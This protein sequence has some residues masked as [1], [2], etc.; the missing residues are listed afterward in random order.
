M[1]LV[2]AFATVA[3]ALPVRDTLVVSSAPGAPLRSIAAA[4]RVARPGDVIRV[5]PGVYREPMIVVDRPVEILG[6]G[7]PVLD[8]E[9]AHQI[10]AVSAD[11]VTVRGLVFRNVGSSHVEDRAALKVVKARGCDVRENRIE[12]GFFGIYLMGVTD[13]RITRNVIVGVPRSESASGNGIHLWSSSRITIEDNEIRGHRD[14]IYF[15]F[16]RESEIRRN[17]S[18][19]NSRY[20]LHFMYSDDCHYIGNTFRDNGAGVAVMYTKR[21]TMAENRFER[22]WGS[23]SYGLL[24]K[25][26]YDARIERNRFVRNTVGLLA[27]GAN[28]IEA[29]QN[30]FEGNGWA[31]KLMAS[32]DGGRFARNNFIGNTF[33]IVTNSRESANELAG[34]YWDSYRG[35]DLNRDG[36]GDVPFHPVRLFSLLVQSNEPSLILLRSLF[37]G[38]LDAAERL[39]PTLTPKALVDRS[40]AMRRIT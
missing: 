34:N 1:S 28:R 31:V 10:M 12:N 38:M 11:D 27:D 35:Y 26:V 30:D 4:V 37:V 6:D 5:G 8:G 39:L 2:L 40:P 7:W 17:R 16:V 32:T 29:H 25:E 9:G 18:E 13:C 23:T 20:G 24:L 14:G 36:V 19:G 3:L 21:I 33:D 15:E 22:N